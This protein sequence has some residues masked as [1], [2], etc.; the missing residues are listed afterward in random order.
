MHCWDAGV[1][2]VETLATL[3]DLVRCDKVRHLGVSNMT[4]WQLQKIVDVSRASGFSPIITL[5]V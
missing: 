4:G 1:P 3:N 5:Q 2:L